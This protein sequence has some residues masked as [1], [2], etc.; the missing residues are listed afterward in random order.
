MP[1]I[2]ELRVLQAL[3]LDMKIR[4][5]QQRI[6]EWVNYYGVDGVYVSFSG[7]K[8]ST[9]VKEETTRELFSLFRMY[10]ENRF[11]ANV[12]VEE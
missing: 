10:I 4:R 1:T 7:G 8:D 12:G 11:G 6:K 5:T 9:V 3:P 2:D